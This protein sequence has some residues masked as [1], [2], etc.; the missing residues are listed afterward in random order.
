M[1]KKPIKKK[2]ENNQLQKILKYHIR[3]KDQ[4]VIRHY[5]IHTYRKR[6]PLIIPFLKRG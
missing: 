5:N 4:G 1:K 2:K 6:T 3:S